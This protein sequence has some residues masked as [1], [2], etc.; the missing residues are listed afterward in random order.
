MP[1]LTSTEAGMPVEEGS[2]WSPI[3]RWKISGDL[4]RLSCGL[5]CGLDIRGARRRAVRAAVDGFLDTRVVGGGPEDGW[6]GL[7]LN[8]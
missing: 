1:A 2:R 7:T 8:A 6:V 3:F 4:A 5:L